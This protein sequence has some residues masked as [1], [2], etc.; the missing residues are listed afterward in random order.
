MLKAQLFE[1]VGGAVL[2]MAGELSTDPATLKLM[3]SIGKH[4][5]NCG[6]FIQKNDGCNVRL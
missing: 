2:P 6:A 3:E 5:P 1:R 4:C